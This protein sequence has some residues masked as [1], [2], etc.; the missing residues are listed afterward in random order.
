VASTTAHDYTW[1]AEAVTHSIGGSVPRRSWSVRLLSGEA[2]VEEGDAMDPGRTRRP[3]DYFL[4]M[5]PL[6][7]L[8]RMVRLTSVKL[9]SRRLRA[10]T[11]G[12]VLK[13]LGSCCWAPGTSSCPGPNLG[14]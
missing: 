5:C 11:V 1:S 12:E 2:P 8:S 13:L 14:V 7:Q 3:L 4:A 6:D 9:D 10:T